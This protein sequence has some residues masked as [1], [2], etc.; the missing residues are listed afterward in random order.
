MVVGHINMKKRHVRVLK[1]LLSYMKQ[2]QQATAGMLSQGL[3]QASNMI[4]FVLIE[5]LLV[6]SL[7]AGLHM[8]KLTKCSRVRA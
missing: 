4:L 3:G 2:S 6:Q 5:G 7:K 1:P 8:S